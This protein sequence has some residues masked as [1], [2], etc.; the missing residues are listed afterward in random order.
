MSDMVAH[1]LEIR[2]K[3]GNLRKKLESRGKVRD[4]ERL[5]EHKNFTI[6]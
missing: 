4:F 3:S 5:P 2:E 1:L 6:P